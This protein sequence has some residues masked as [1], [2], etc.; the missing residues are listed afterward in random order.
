MSTTRDL[1]SVDIRKAANGNQF[2]E[3]NAESELKKGD[4]YVSSKECVGGMNNGYTVTMSCTV[5]GFGEVFENNE[6]IE[7]KR[8]YISKIDKTK[9]KTG[10]AT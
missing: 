5:E 6:G 7:R 10:R 9:V 4:H 2:I 8:A 3:V 1:K